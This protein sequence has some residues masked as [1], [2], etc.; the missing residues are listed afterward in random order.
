[1]LKKVFFILAIA[2][3][4]YL[5][6]LLFLSYQ[7]IA[8]GLDKESLI[9]TYYSYQGTIL[10]SNIIVFFVL[11]IFSNLL[12]YKQ[13]GIGFFIISV[14]IF[15]IVVLANNWFI[16]RQFFHLKDTPGPSTNE[17]NL[18]IMLAVF[19]CIAA[20][21]ISAISAITIRNLKSRK[22]NFLYTF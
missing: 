1:M 6:L 10:L 14:S 13:K 17:Y 2:G 8:S 18:S 12:F 20:V 7:T 9:Q 11:L 5:G 22:I 3:T 15:I 16:T 19:Y 4:I 21:A